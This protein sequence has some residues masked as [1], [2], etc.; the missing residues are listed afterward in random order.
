MRSSIGAFSAAAALALGLLTGAT[1]K[2]D[3]L[4]M[5]ERTSG[6]GVVAKLTELGVAK[7]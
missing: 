4:K 2:A 6:E 3:E 7:R 5:G 1:L